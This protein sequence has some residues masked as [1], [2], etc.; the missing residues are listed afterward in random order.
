M[1]WRYVMDMQGCVVWWNDVGLCEL[2]GQGVVD[3][4]VQMNCSVVWFLESVELLR[5][6]WFGIE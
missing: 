2:E 4:V 1:S 3:V 6:C 5:V